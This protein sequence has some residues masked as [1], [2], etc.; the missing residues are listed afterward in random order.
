MKSFF[1]QPLVA[2]IALAFAPVALATSTQLAS[3]GDLADLSLEQLSNIEVTSVSGRAEPL[4]QAAA[5]IFVISAQDIRR[6]GALSLPEV[7]RLAPNLQ[8]AQV[9][10]GQYAIS[11]RGFGN[12]IANKLLVL[13][14][15]RTVY[16]PLFSGV[17]WDA[18][19]V[20]LED[21]ERI[22]VISGP[23]GTIWGANAVNGVINVI[24]RPASATRG[25]L[26][27][28]ARS[29]G[30]GREVARHG[31][32][33]GDRAWLRVYGLASDR[34]N[35]RLGNGTERQDASTRRQLGFRGDW[36]DGVS[37][38]T[39]QGEVYREAGDTPASNLA[40]N[41]HGGHLLARWSTRA[42][43][44]TAY[45]VQGYYDLA[46]RDEETV[47]RNRVQTADVQFTVAPKLS[48]GQLLM[49]GGWRTAYDQNQPTA[50]V[51]FDPAKRR[52]TWANLF[53]QYQVPLARDWELTTGLKAERN[54]YTGL[55]YL[56]NLR[57]AWRHSPQSTSWAGLSR[58]VRA[59]ARIDREFFFPGRA[60]FFIAGGPNFRSETANVVEFGH[61]GQVGSR[62]SYSV[63]AFQ[64]YYK[65]LRAG[66]PG[67]LPA[68]PENQIQGPA[69]GVEAWS[70]W[71]VTPDWQ[72]A[73]GVSTLR[74]QLRFTSG[75]TDATSI[76]N[77]GNDPNHQWNLRSSWNLGRG[78]E[79]DLMVRRVGSLP[80][81]AVPAYT[82]L[83]A[84]L[85]VQVHPSVRVALLGRN[86]LDRRHVEFEP[87]ASASQ[88]ERRWWLQVNWQL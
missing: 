54:S 20:M 43:S 1:V 34:D 80:V 61:R 28:V 10:A 33:I 87:L 32:A 12:P 84:R 31:M 74:K 83:D 9:S 8:V 50:L 52:L 30:G 71:E 85:A 88:L 3:L 78:A 40:A 38:L 41:Q 68:Q 72:L 25:S 7:L 35:T 81:P 27:S 36:E 53:A 22:E 48:A 67:R 17:F 70:N 62:L 57:L 4:R 46:D 82:A 6:S 75:A 14:D 5:S 69:R 79:L 64:Q 26:V 11:A 63:T 13:I 60:P 2:A 59:P 21:V 37:E 49:G 66:I 56:P 24:T 29:H 58:V 19:D 39:L 47:F 44:G 77:L 65:G 86:L 18:N 55:E 76:P 51:L 15:G 23:G 73:A 45:T 16:S 42:A